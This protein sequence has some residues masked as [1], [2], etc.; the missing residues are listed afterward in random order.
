[1]EQNQLVIFSN[2]IIVSSY[3]SLGVRPMGIVEFLK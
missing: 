3:L 1:M 2:Q